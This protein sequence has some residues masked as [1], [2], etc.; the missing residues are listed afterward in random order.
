MELLDKLRAKLQVGEVKFTFKRKSDG[1]ERV[2]RGTLSPELIP[3][4]ENKE[5]EA[6]R[7]KSV[8]RLQNESVFTYYDLDRGAFRSFNKDSLISIE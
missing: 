2:A 3:Q 5:K 6:S 7:A 4:P 1:A 8:K